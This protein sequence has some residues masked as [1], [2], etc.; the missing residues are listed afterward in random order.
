MYPLV[1]ISR[2]MQEG[3]WGAGQAQAR[4]G[5]GGG[6]Q[7]YLEGKT[8]DWRVLKNIS[9]RRSPPWVMSYK[10]FSVEEYFSIWFLISSHSV[11]K[12]VKNNK[13]CLQISFVLSKTHFS[14]HISIRFSFFITFRHFQALY[15]KFLKILVNME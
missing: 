12:L 3:V 11:N 1:D 4:G 7:C 9:F 5:G 13:I 10:D 2:D 8:T 6:E 14:N 15:I